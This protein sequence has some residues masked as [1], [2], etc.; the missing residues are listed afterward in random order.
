MIS[1]EFAQAEIERL[2][3][4]DTYHMKTPQAL[5]ELIRV[6]MESASESEAHRV[7][8]I[9]IETERACPT[10]AD[11]RNMLRA[12][13]PQPEQREQHRGCPECQGTGYVIV[14]ELVTRTGGAGGTLRQQLSGEA[15]ERE[16]LDQWRKEWAAKQKGAIRDQGIQCR[17]RVCQCRRAA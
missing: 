9:W 2:D 11:L 16:I 3:A 5:Q 7:I 6:L 14:Y 12:Q 15:E 4:T 13:D 10:P 8:S 17:A 1:L